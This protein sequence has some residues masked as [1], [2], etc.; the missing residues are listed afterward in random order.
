[1]SSMSAF[2]SLLCMPQV[3]GCDYSFSN[4]EVEYFGGIEVM[5]FLDFEE[6]FNGGLTFSV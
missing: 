4:E 5:A 2:M 1:M 3:V 6:I